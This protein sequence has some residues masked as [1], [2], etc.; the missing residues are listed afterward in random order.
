MTLT[1]AQNNAAAQV[2]SELKNSESLIP[3]DIMVVIK[4]C[5]L[6]TVAERI[7]KVQ[8]DALRASLTKHNCTLD[9]SGLHGEPDDIIAVNKEFNEIGASPYQIDDSE[10]SW[11]SIEDI[12]P[13]HLTAAQI[14]ALYPFIKK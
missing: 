11:L 7:L 2:L 1:L 12:K 5:D 14:A 3:D 9:S 10:I 4:I 6:A 13:L 8:Q